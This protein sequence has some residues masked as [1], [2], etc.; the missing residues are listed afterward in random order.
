MSEV[1]QEKLGFTEELGF[2]VRR[3]YPVEPH[4][5]GVSEDMNNVFNNIPTVCINDNF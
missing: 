3:T 4:Q 2:D 1:T 5:K